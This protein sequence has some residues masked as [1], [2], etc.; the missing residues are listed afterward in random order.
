MEEGKREE[1]D[2]YGGVILLCLFGGGGQSNTFGVRICASRT[3]HTQK[4]SA[5]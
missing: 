1:V 5:S 2:L 3:G 4:P